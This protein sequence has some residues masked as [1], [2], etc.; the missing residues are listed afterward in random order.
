MAPEK[1]AWFLGS[2]FNAITITKILFEFPHTLGK[3]SQDSV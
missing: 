1:S 3:I 2:A